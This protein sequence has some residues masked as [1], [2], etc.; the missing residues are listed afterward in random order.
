MIK[1]NE[2]KKLVDKIA[3]VIEMSTKSGR[4]ITVGTK[5]E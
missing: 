2:K 4:V 3:F 5:L 1:N